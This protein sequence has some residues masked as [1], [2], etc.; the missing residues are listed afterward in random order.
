MGNA[1]GALG[2]EGALE[3]AVRLAARGARWDIVM[4]LAEELRARRAK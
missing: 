4:F 3:E 2:E 1:E